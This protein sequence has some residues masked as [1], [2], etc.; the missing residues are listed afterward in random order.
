MAPLL[1][2]RLF[3]SNEPQYSL[4]TSVSF[5]LDLIKLKLADQS[6]VWHC[7]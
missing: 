6:P 1:L 3:L 7:Q 4:G 5:A 2:R